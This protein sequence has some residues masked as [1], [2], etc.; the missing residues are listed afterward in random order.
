[1]RRT[2]LLFLGVL[3]SCGGSDAATNGDD[4]GA[5]PVDGGTNDAPADSPPDAGA[6]TNT[7]VAAPGVAITDKGAVHGAASPDAKSY[8][9][10][11]IPYA[12]PPVGELR[13]RPPTEHPCWSS[14]LEATTFGSMCLQLGSG[15]T[16]TVGSEDCLT[17]NVFAPATATPSTKLPILFFVHGGGNVQGA[18]SDKTANGITLYDGSVLAAKE[19]AIVVTFNYRLGPMGFLS[20]PDFAAEAPDKGSGNYGLRDQI[21][22]LEWVKRNA[23]AFGGDASHVLLFGESAGA[24]DVCA[25]V[26]S[27]L[28][29]GLFSAA[30]MESGGCVANA[31]ATATAFGSQFAQKVGCSN[32][33]C[34]RGIDASTIELAFPESANVAG[35]KQSDFQPNVDGVMLTATP[36][37]MIA[38]G[39]HNHVPFV[40]G[41]N[42]NETGQAIVTQFPS[43]M[44]QPQFDAALL[45][46]AGG[47]QT[48]ASSVAAMYPAS[49]YG[50][51]L[52]ATF[53][54]LTTDSKFVCTVRYDAR[55]AAKGQ[56]EPVR[57]FYFSHVLDGTPVLAAGKSYGAFHGLELLFVFDHIAPAGYA[58]SAGET[59]L[60][61]AMG[62]Y[63][64]RLAATGD[65]NG[66]SAPAWPVYDA[67]DTALQLDDTVAPITGVRTKQCDYWDTLL[68]R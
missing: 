54:A 60:A 68:G 16:T 59:A 5:P 24:V 44:T 43:G 28:A 56:T 38:A 14:T 2:I 20:H 41:G 1:M 22:A 13:W 3:A 15:G 39:T 49:D 31:G 10:L 65:P 66:A 63:W 45:A 34:L 53:I 47:N 8:S 27:P 52:R 18:S 42:A 9:F 7:A 4:G 37:E 17:I 55:A 21:A 46:Y 61:D 57:R 51:D 62:G 19:N 64:S 30:L 26:A 58:P 6:C 48:V 11:G 35:S 25:L 33:A 40:I 36:H 50:D 67:T 32:A 23:A 29:K 12:T